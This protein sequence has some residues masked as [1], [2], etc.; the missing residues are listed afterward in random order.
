MDAIVDDAV[1]QLLLRI[2]KKEI[3][4]DAFELICEYVKYHF[5]TLAE[6]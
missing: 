4:C 2:S 6:Q 5:T 1:I 3:N